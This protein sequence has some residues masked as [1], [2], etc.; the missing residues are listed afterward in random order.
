MFAWTEA[1]WIRIMQVDFLGYF[2][3]ACLGVLGGFFLRIISDLN[4]F[5]ISNVA[6]NHSQ[7]DFGASVY[8]CHW[9]IVLHVKG[10]RDLVANK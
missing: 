1:E 9:T 7:F 4:I 8:S 6:F 3:R 2:S 5:V 10:C